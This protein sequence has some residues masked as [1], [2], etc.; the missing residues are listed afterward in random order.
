MKRK[1]Q[2]L[3]QPATFGAANRIDN[4]S[5]QVEQVSELPTTSVAM[6]SRT[7]AL[8]SESLENPAPKRT[9]R[10]VPV[11]LPSSIP[12]QK[13]GRKKPSQPFEP[14]VSEESTEESSPPP[15][16]PPMLTLPQTPE[17][18]EVVSLPQPTLENNCPESVG[19]VNLIQNLIQT[20]HISKLPKFGGTSEEDFKSWF[21]E[22]Y[23]ATEKRGLTETEQISILKSKLKGSARTVF[24]GF[25]ATKINTLQKLKTEMLKTFAP[26]EEPAELRLRLHEIRPKD[27][28]SLRIFARTLYGKL[29]QAFS[30]MDPQA[31]EM[32]AISYF[33]RAVSTELGNRIASRRPET[34][35]QAIEVALRYENDGNSR[36]KALVSAKNTLQLLS[37]GT[38]ESMENSTSQE[39][40]KPEIVPKRNGGNQSITLCALMEQMKNNNKQTCQQISELRKEITSEKPKSNPI[41]STTPVTVIGNSDSSIPPLMPPPSRLFYREQNQNRFRTNRFQQYNRRLQFSSDRN[42][43]FDNRRCFKCHQE[44]H[45]ARNC[46]NGPEPNQNLNSE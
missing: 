20:N 16:E 13:K 19:Y 18:M 21:D 2:A 27:G 4:P 14:P 39:T 17:I 30:T 35:E 43:M 45:I 25:Q 8:I 40:V 38:T 41:N 6:T 46:R 10:A 11:I 42:R 9:R 32:L 36:K 24:E 34:L 26:L 5:P 29:V 23:S 37:E 22:F 31:A 3:V 7:A 44:G 33:I 12:T 15:P 1:T 28:E